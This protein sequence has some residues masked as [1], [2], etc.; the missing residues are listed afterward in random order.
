MREHG[1]RPVLDAFP[2]IEPRRSN[3]E[4]VFA[5]GESLPENPLHTPHPLLGKSRIVETG[6]KADRRTIAK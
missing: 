1:I 4:N 6:S 2:N 3:L 5:K